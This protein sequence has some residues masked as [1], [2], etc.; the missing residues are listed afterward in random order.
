MTICFRVFLLID[1][2]SLFSIYPF[3]LDE[4]RMPIKIA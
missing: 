3:L 1:S 2:D 4:A